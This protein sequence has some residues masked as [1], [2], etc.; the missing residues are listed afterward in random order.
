[1][2]LWLQDEPISS[3]LYHCAW[4][5][6]WGISAGILSLEFQTLH[7]AIS[8]NTSTLVSSVKRT[9][10]QRSCG[11]SRKP[12]QAIL[13]QLSESF[14]LVINKLSLLNDEI[15]IVW[16]LPYNPDWLAAITVSLRSV[17]MSYLDDI[18]ITYTKNDPNQKPAANFG[19]YE[20]GDICWWSSNSCVFDLQQ[21]TV[22]YSL[23]VRKNKNGVFHKWFMLFALCFFKWPSLMYHV[24][25]FFWDC[26]YLT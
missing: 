4:Q 26:V 15:Q 5:S 19:V 7:S 8:P 17:L 24:F 23:N 12:K 18:V 22:S 20:G 1:M 6:L 14:P 13:E 16:K 11:L 9:L 3:P 2:V 10:F 21:L 25:L